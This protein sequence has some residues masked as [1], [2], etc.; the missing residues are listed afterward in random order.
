MKVQC[1][2]MVNALPRLFNVQDLVLSGIANIT[3]EIAVETSLLIK[4]FVR[5][6]P[7]F[8]QLDLYTLL[9]VS[10]ALLPF[11]RSNLRFRWETTSAA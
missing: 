7:Q 10:F 8:R 4:D 1:D 2:K 11:S 9:A 3:D 5:T 6:N